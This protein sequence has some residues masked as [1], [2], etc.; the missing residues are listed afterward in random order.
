MD[1][2]EIIIVLTHVPDETSANK[3]AEMLI[4]HQ[5][6]ACVNIQ[7]PCQSVY[8]WN[9]VIEKT[10]EWPVTIKTIRQK[11]AEVESCILKL[12][13]YELPDILCLN[14]DGGLPA[15]LQWVNAQIP[16]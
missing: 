2:A 1:N 12:H 14:V 8:A 16:Q 13:P 10:I 3:L 7:S 6:A 4:Q 5:L 9:N 15:Y 11:Y